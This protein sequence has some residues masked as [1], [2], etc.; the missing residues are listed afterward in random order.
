MINISQRND[1]TYISLSRDMCSDIGYEH[2]DFVFLTNLG[3]K[4]I[5]S[6]DKLTS[7]SK[8]YCLHGERYK[9]IILTQMRFSKHNFFSIKAD[10][11]Y[12]FEGLEF[13]IPEKIPPEK[14]IQGFIPS[15]DLPKVLDRLYKDRQYQDFCVG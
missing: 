3:N 10:W 13:T 14:L 1:G 8:S 7:D 6:K 2:G 9:N 11:D 4:G 12:C 5:I 15:K